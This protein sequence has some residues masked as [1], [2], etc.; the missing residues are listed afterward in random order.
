MASVG[1]RLGGG[2]WRRL[3][4]RQADR[5]E[6]VRHHLHHVVEAGGDGRG[7]LQADVEARRLDADDGDVGGRGITS[8]STPNIF[9]ACRLVNACSRG[10]RES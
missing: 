7:Q 4:R 5:R 9:V 1:A 8:E 6:F 2:A 10:F 3:S